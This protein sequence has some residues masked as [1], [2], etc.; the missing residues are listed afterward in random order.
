MTLQSY[1]WAYIWRKTL[2][3]RIH[4]PTMFIAA[5]FRIAKTRK[6][7]KCPSIE[8]DKD[9]AHIRNGILCAS[10]VAQLVSH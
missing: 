6:Q 7:P 1:S 2:S 8:M 3:K 10:L 4:V 5:L 9:V